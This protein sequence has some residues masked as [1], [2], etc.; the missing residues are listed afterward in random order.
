[1]DTIS[2]SMKE[3]DSLMRDRR[4]LECLRACGVDNWDYFDDAMDML[5]D[6]IE[7]KPNNA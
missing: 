1:M 4:I 5:D 6:I 2:I 3:Y 7:E